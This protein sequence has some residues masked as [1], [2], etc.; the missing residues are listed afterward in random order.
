M[1][2]ESGKVTSEVIERTV[3]EGL[4]RVRP[5]VQKWLGDLASEVLPAEV[6]SIHLEVFPDDFGRGL[7]VQVFWLNEDGDEVYL[8]R[9]DGSWKSPSRVRSSLPKLGSIVSQ[10]VTD[11]WV[12]AAPD[13]P[14]NELMGAAC[15]DFLADV[16]AGVLAAP[17][18]RRIT[19]GLHDDEVRVLV[20]P[21]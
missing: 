1:A 20:N 7:P 16:L 21:A 8:R 4:A 17:P 11:V 6:Q 10:R 5:D 2:A 3:R 19:T 12:R 15:M 14:V 18:S 9:A 13:L